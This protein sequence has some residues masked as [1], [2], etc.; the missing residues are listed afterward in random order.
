MRIDS[1][2]KCNSRIGFGFMV[3]ASSRAQARE[4]SGA[5]G[6]LTLQSRYVDLGVLILV[7]TT[8]DLQFAVCYNLYG[9]TA[10]NRNRLIMISNSH[11]VN[12]VTFIWQW[13]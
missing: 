8:F 10:A 7:V 3:I 11:E 4:A 2:P 1:E 6:I 9:R 13:S 5:C 12:L